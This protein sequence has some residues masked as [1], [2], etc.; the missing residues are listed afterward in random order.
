MSLHILPTEIIQDIALRLPNQALAN[1]RLASKKLAYMTCSNSFYRFIFA[2]I[3]DIAHVSGTNNQWHEILTE[4]KLV[5]NPKQWY[6]FHE[7]GDD[8]VQVALG[9][10]EALILGRQSHRPIFIH[11]Y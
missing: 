2:N 7:L 9:V 10:I 11:C 1:L 3:F 6:D 8:K 4:R 5:L